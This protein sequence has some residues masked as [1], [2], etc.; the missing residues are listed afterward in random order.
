M[1][2]K[3]CALPDAPFFAL[4]Y[5][6]TMTAHRATAFLAAFNDIEQHLRSILSAKDSDSF[7]WIVDRARDKHIISGRQAEA[8]KDFSNLRNAISHGR[9]Y[10]SEP[11]A[12]PNAA[13]VEQISN[14]RD[15]VVSPPETLRILQPQKVFT[16]TSST[17][18]M[19]AFCTIRDKDFSQIPIYDEGKF[20]ALLTTNTIARWVAAD[21]S[22]N[23]ELNAADIADIV[24]YQEP[25]DRAIFLART[26]SVQETMDQL[27]ETDNQGHRPYAAVITEHGKV[28]ETPLRLV[29]PADLPVLFDALEWE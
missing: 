19:D 12:E 29:T 9:Y 27:S 8:L 24:Q 14:L 4:A 10:R 15:I 11:I 1:R 3:P 13:V 7:W 26:V 20:I 22:D 23:H 5:T 25:S 21:F 17:S 2:C 6:G 16:L 28:N 18:I